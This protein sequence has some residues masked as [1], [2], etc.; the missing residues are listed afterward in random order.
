M[1]SRGLIREAFF[2]DGHAD[3]FRNLTLQH[4]HFED[5]ASGCHITLPRMREANQNL[6]IMAIYTT[7]EERGDASAVTALRILEN[8]RGQIE[9][10]G[11]GVGLVLDRDDLSRCLQSDVPHVL[12][13][14]EGA[15]PLVGSLEILHLFYRAGL[16]A[17][18]LTHNHNSVAAG[19][20]A[21]PD[22]ERMGLTSFGKDLIPAMNRLGMMIDTAHL[23]RAALEEVLELSN[24]PVV[25]SHSCC[26]H[27]VDLERN[28][29]DAQIRSIAATGGVVAVTY[30]P[31]F[32]TVEKRPVTSQDVFRHLERMVEFAGE[33]HVAIG[34]DF[35]GVD[36]LPGDLRDP[37]DTASL[38]KHML[39]AGWSRV[40]VEK[41]L[42]LNWYRV[43]Q[44]VLKT[45]SIKG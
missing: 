34:S 31:K 43:L 16:R 10:I 39:D 44:E 12:L 4:A 29:Q 32:L 14:M 15:D 20:C 5:E 23:G 30:V 6:Q 18:G 45:P 13:S 2:C 21:P 19:G 9:R 33:D 36:L 11:P 41:V 8:A 27:F 22:G 35:D 37:R 3:T 26:A 28:L 25:N 24:A 1:E 42:G 7:Y 17:I 38:V 40:Q